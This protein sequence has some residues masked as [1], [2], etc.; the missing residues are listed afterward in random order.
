MKETNT[1]ENKS[2]IMS[3]IATVPVTFDTVTEEITETAELVRVRVNGKL[4]ATK[5]EAIAT[6]TGM[7][8][9]V[10]ELL[11][12]LRERGVGDD[13]IAERWADVVSE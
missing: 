9:K 1:S 8:R 7:G 6:W 11:K 10:P 13:Q 4:P 3:T 2:L 5:S 12:R